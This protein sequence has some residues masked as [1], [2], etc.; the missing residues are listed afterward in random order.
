M[1]D[2]KVLVYSNLSK[3]KYWK[4]KKSP[5]SMRVG[6]FHSPKYRGKVQKAREKGLSS[7]LLIPDAHFFVMMWSTLDGWLQHLTALPKLLLKFSFLH[8]F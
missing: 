3:I 7:N 8:N 6:R 1:V 2:M 5:T 4:K